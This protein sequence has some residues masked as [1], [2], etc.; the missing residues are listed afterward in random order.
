MSAPFSWRRPV[1]KHIHLALAQQN[2]RLLDVADKSRVIRGRRAAS[3][4][5][6]AAPE[7]REQL[8]PTTEHAFQ[9][10]RAHSVSDANA[11]SRWIFMALRWAGSDL[12]DNQPSESATNVFHDSPDVNEFNLPSDGAFQG[13]LS[14]DAHDSISPLLWCLIKILSSASHVNGRD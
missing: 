8:I 2:H 11:S 7:R 4:L 1:L 14:F 3:N 13:F 6:A 12:N 5:S 9:H 10:I